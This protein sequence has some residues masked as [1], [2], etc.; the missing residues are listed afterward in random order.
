MEKKQDLNIQGNSYLAYNFRH[1]TILGSLQI[2]L[3]APRLGR[4]LKKIGT[5]NRREKTGKN[6]KTGFLSINNTQS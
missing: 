1:T 3:V 6:R 4:F 2:N 5:E